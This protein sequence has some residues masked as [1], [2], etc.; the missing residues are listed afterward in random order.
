M[1]QYYKDDPNDNIVNSETFKFKINMTGKTP[2]AGNTKNF[3][4]ALPLKYLS[5]F[6]KTPEMPLISCK[7]NLIL[8]W[9]E[10][11]VFFLQLEK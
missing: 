2:D 9:H 10:N 1:W 11:C 4:I 7:I 6:G 5:N 3:K 8:T